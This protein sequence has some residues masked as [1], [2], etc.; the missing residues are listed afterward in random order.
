MS[1]NLLLTFKQQILDTN[2]LNNID[3]LKTKLGIETDIL[4]IESLLS[5]LQSEIEKSK[6][7][8]IASDELYIEKLYD[9]IKMFIAGNREVDIDYVDRKFAHI[10]KYIDLQL[11]E[12]KQNKN[13]NL[14]K[15]FWTNIDKLNTSTK[16]ILKRNCK[17]NNKNDFQK[18]SKYEILKEIVFNYKNIH[19]LNYL[20]EKYNNIFLIK[21]VEGKS[22]FS[23][24]VTSYVDILMDNN[25]SL[26]DIMYYETVIDIF[27]SVP[28]LTIEK[29]VKELV[30][31]KIHNYKNI[32]DDHNNR[33]IYLLELKKKLNN[34][35]EFV[36]SIDELNKKYN[37]NIHIKNYDNKI[38]LKKSPYVLC[39]NMTDKNVITIDGNSTVDVDDGISLE[40]LENGNYLLSTYITD[41][42]KYV[43]HNSFYD[44]EALHHIS[45][46][47]SGDRLI[48]HLITSNFINN[49]CSLLPGDIKETLA[50]FFEIDT[51]GN[52]VN[53]YSNRV[54]VTI[55][56]ECHL[57]YAKVNN[58]LKNE[59]DSSLIDRTLLDLN[60]LTGKGIF[61]TLGTEDSYRDNVSPS[62]NVVSKIM[63]LTNHTAA[64][65]SKEKGIPFIYSACPN[66][67]NAISND[68]Y[69]INNMV[70][71]ITN[72]NNDQLLS[73]IISDAN[74]PKCYYT[75]KPMSHRAMNNSVY[76]TLSSPLRRY[77][78]LL[79]QRLFCLFN[80][81]NSEIS[82]KQIYMIEEILNEIVDYLNDNKAMPNKYGYDYA[83]IKKAI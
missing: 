8:I 21:N 42:S 5:L 72:Q 66:V 69:S 40:R 13:L 15:L 11:Y 35:K 34:N 6:Y 37:V 77:V 63:L 64:L 25:S 17:S 79:N 57:S 44:I 71:S 18:I 31:K 16:N 73:K 26:R 51:D 45:S 81:S 7:Y 14:F 58:I 36:D 29:K 50:F 56:K 30:D 47:H 19:L 68:C 54:T 55:K 74:K 3:E 12:I 80:F 60:N 62:Q 9:Y 67:D 75:T 2:F 10:T 20:K 33:A 24:L 78:D 49:K 1:S 76:G 61:N 65:V 82:N 53:Y 43:P 38:L 27:L 59:Q 70:N 41:V 52:V 83:H 4:L 48:R 46:M 39:Q 23:E 32:L 28:R 22:F